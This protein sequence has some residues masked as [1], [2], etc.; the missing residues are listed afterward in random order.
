MK[1]SLWFP[2]WLPGP[3]RDTLTL[4][5]LAQSKK[6]TRQK[7]PARGTLALSPGSDERHF[8][9]GAS[10]QSKYM[11][12]LVPKPN[13]RPWP[14]WREFPIEGQDFT[15]ASP[16]SKEANRMQIEGC[17]C[18]GRKTLIFL[19]FTLFLPLYFHA[20]QYGC[21]SVGFYLSAFYYFCMIV[22]KIGHVWQDKNN[23]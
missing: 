21:N 1:R 19:A 12:W 18:L 17:Y 10:L 6:A 9:A 7:G 11:T 22:S 2:H 16:Q 13:R 5:S 20:I 14:H 8:H 4:I 23:K 15:D 3:A